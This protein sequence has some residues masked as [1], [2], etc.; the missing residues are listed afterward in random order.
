MDILTLLHAALWKISLV[1]KGLKAYTEKA[2]KY[3][4]EMPGTI[5]EYRP[6]PS[7]HHEVKAQEHR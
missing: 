4:Q 5:T 2:S 6:N 1:C 3:D 7:L